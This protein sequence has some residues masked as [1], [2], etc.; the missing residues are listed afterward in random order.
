MRSFAAALPVAAAV[1]AVSLACAPKAEIAAPAPAPRTPI[2][3]PFDAAAPMIPLGVVITK[4]NPHAGVTTPAFDVMKHVTVMDNVPAD[5][6]MTAMLVLKTDIGADCEEC[7]VKGERWESDEVKA[8]ADTRQMIRLSM[9]VNDQYFKREARVTCY[10][11]HRGRWTPQR[12]PPLDDK[13]KPAKKKAPKLST[14]D[15]SNPSER[16][17]KS[18]QSFKGQKAAALMTAMSQW[19]AS[20]GVE[21]THCHTDNGKWEQDHPQ[22]DVTRQMMTMTKRLNDTWFKGENVITCW[23]CHG[24]QAIPD[25]TAPVAMRSPK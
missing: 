1:V 13:V 23:G 18:V 8:K 16:V 20:V 7:H 21:C 25:R 11:C 5:R 22:K 15:A 19:T 17:F 12:D 9:Q 4:D 14:A 24:G 3:G 6:F 10:T 2:P